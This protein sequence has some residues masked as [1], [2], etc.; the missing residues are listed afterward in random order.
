MAKQKNVMA[1]IIFVSKD[2][3]FD[4]ICAPNS[5]FWHSD[6]RRNNTK[7]FQRKIFAKCG[8]N[9]GK[10]SQQIPKNV[11]TSWYLSQKNFI[12]MPICALN[13]AFW[14]SDWWRNSPKRFKRK[15]LAL[16]GR[17]NERIS[18]EMSKNVTSSLFSQ[19]IMKAHIYSNLIFYHTGMY[20][21]EF[22]AYWTSPL[23]ALMQIMWCQIFCQCGKKIPW[24]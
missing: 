11:T 23:G 4:T 5:T 13:P 12:L 22:G 17:N 18:Q 9:N 8:R 1:V 10:I 6:W 7:R 16:C 20:I 14:H 21:L 2:L 15:I 3:H 24:N 19:K